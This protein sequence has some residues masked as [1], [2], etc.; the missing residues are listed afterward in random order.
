MSFAAQITSLTR[1][2][3]QSGALGLPWTI[4]A[5]PHFGLL[6]LPPL[7]PVTEVPPPP[8]MAGVAGR[9]IIDADMAAIRMTA[10]SRLPG[11][12]RL[13]RSCLLTCKIPVSFVGLRG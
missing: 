10:L 6:P 2:G 4:L 11:F 1:W 8:A 5:S 12:P 7:D 3:A 13:E 9:A